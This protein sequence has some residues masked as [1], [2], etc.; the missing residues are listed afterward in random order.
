MF[1]HNKIRNQD[2][3]AEIN[4]SRSR[5]TNTWAHSEPTQRF[6]IRN[7][8][9]P[10]LHKPFAKPFTRWGNIPVSTLDIKRE[11]TD[12]VHITRYAGHYIVKCRET[13]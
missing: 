1:N 2:M 13:F 7:L 11:R 9:W 10:N 8:A 6:P 3:T 5:Y 12:M 4:G